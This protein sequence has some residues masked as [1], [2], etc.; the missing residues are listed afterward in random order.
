MYLK[1]LLYLC[2]GQQ[3]IM[4][5]E[6]LEKIAKVNYWNGNHFNSGVERTLYL[7]RIIPYIG[8]RVIKVVTGQRRAGKSWL[9]RQVM[10]SMLKN[11]VM[12]PSQI[13][14]VNKEFYRFSFLQTADDLMNLYETYCS[15]INPNKKSYVFFDEVHNIPGW[16]RVIDSLS[17][18]PSIDCEVFLTGSNSKMLSGELS[19][20]LSGRYVEFEV[21]PFSYREYLKTENSSPSRSTMISYLCSGGL[22]EFVNLNGEETKRHYVESVKDTILLRD[23]VE[24]YNIK[25]AAL[26]NS[27]FAYLVNNGTSLVSVSNVVNYLNNEQSKRN[28]KAKEK[29]YETVS[30]YICYLT[31]AVVILKADRYDLKGKEILKGAAKFYA[32]DNSYHNYLFD[33]FG[34]GQGALLESYVYQAVRRAGW[35]VYVGRVQNK[36]V[37][38]V[39]TDHDNRLY[40]QS[41]WTIEDEET[42]ERE[43]SSLESVDD[44]YPKI[45]VTMEDITRKNRN[46]IQNIQAWNLED[47]LAR[48]S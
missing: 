18:D 6:R 4:M 28:P 7:D 10:A 26:L 14:Y 30:N 16:E 9:L 38:F 25:D 40:V 21:Q 12:D 3:K 17:Q 33:G 45:V 36:E 37:D 13:L 20:L 23:I 8:N 46:G 27:I 35:K 19:T 2:D 41:S 39:C 42:A 43:Y 44:S 31:D 1:I 24:R 47:Y 11:G 34:F 5:D 48:L 22:P 15:E 29:N 32:N